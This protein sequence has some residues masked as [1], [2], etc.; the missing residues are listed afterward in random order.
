[1][2]RYRSLDVQ[3]TIF[4][5]LLCLTLVAF[6]INTWVVSFQS[7]SNAEKLWGKIIGSICGWSIPGSIIFL[8]GYGIYRINTHVNNEEHDDLPKYAQGTELWACWII[9][10]VFSAF[11]AGIIMAIISCNG[12]HR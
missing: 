4:L 10:F 2:D 8:T 12:V 5:T 9:T 3:M 11:I 7:W 6:A 1:M